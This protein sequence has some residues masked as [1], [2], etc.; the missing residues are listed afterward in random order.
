MKQYLD[1]EI[2]MKSRVCSCSGW[3]QSS[4]ASCRSRPA[5]LRR[6][7]YSTSPLCSLAHVGAWQS[8]CRPVGDESKAGCSALVKSWLWWKMKQASTEDGGKSSCTRQ[9]SAV[10]T[11]SYRWH[12]RFFRCYIASK[13]SSPT[14]MN[15]TNGRDVLYQTCS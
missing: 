15:R 9:A 7:S 2:Q 14:M 10:N 4:C 5:Y 8:T 12:Y 1:V 13:M 11:W 3:L 6:A